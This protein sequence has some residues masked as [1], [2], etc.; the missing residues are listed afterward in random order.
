MIISVCSVFPAAEWARRP[1]NPG[2]VAFVF[3]VF[4]QA[5]S[6]QSASATNGYYSH[7]LGVK[8]KSMAGAGTASPEESLSAAL[9]PAAALL[10]DSRWEI[11][12][13]L[14]SPRRGYT[15]S[16][17][18]A[19]GNGGAFTI[20]AG[21]VDSGREYFL[22]P[23]VGKVWRL[24]DHAAMSF[25]LYG[26]GGMN[27]DYTSG[28]ASLDPDGPGPAP[29][30]SLPGPY[31]GGNA[32]IDLAQ[33]FVDVGY[34]RQFGELSLGINAVL[35][36]QRFEARGLSNFA[37]FTRHFAA[38]GGTAFPQDLT[39]N[40][41]DIS[42]GGGFKLGMIWQASP[43]FN[44]AASYQ[45]QISMSEFDDY[46]DLFAE[47]GSFDIPP[48]LRMGAS[49]RPMPALGL[50]LDYEKTWYSEV[51][52]VGNPLSNLFA[53]PT[54]G[55][56][57]ADLDSCLGGSRGAGFGWDD[58]DTIKFGIDWRY[59]PDLILR[60]GYSFSNQPIDDSQVLFNM[61]APGVME[62]HVTFG[63][64]KTTR[65]DKEFNMMLM[66]APTEKVDGINPFDPTQTIRLEMKQFELEFSYRF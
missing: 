54:A 63:F 22:I 6:I 10:V 66:Y 47:Q 46:G 45:T 36:V 2:V 57:G 32:G 20:D 62:H 49:W 23:H 30:M 58:V 15:A 33:L 53:C 52:S 56:G 44:L 8:N 41:H 43:S 50:H 65:N 19:N 29:V 1:V 34:A 28:S 37:G 27:T 31:G 14:F 4:L 7:G 5:I 35:A 9:N 13:A 64:T 18:L 12:A 51:D 38:S 61:L 24:N 48:V 40:K 16:S 59:R 39:D 42:T 11:G 17:S 25:N 60:A 21:K 55:A 3:L 26:R